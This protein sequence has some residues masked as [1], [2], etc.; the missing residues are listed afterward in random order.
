MDY[1][2]ITKTKLIIPKLWDKDWEQAINDSDD[3]F[4]QILKT[5]HRAVTLL[6]NIDDN[7]FTFER[8]AWLCLWTRLF[9]ILDG[10][11]SSVYHK[12]E[13]ILNILDRVLF[14]Y[15]IQIF[16][17]AEKDQ[18]DRLIA[19]SAWCLYNDYLFQESILNPSTM[20]GVW[21]IEEE[22]EILEDL[23]GR[24]IREKLFGPI[25]DSNLTTDYQE[26]NRKKFSHKSQEY[27]KQ[28]RIRKWFE[29]KQISPWIKK[30]E[31]LK[32][33]S[34]SI[35]QLFD[36]TERNFYLRLKNLK[37]N[38]K[39]ISFAYILY[40]QSSMSIHGSSF[41]DYFTISENSIIPNFTGTTAKVEESIES[42]CS[43]SNIVI[44]I[45]LILR[46]YAWKKQ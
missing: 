18:K 15:T 22:K 16:T 46:N 13:L 9:N 8:A 11:K 33:K 34:P 20:E 12:T 19:F 38:D 21:D 32:K 1:F 5:Q 37:L 27:K 41:H 40:K 44:P 42:I 29:N 39:D 28:D 3:T 26:A 2:D 31:S 23:E 7:S 45:L 43:R 6:K 36:K 25:N 17:I 14:E 35:F 30:I 4:K 10:I 24:Q